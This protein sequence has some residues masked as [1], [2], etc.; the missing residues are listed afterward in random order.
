M[1]GCWH[2]FGRFSDRVAKHDPLIASAFVFVVG[3]IDTLGDIN[4]LAMQIILDLQC[5]P[6]KTLLCVPDLAHAV[7]DDPLDL[8]VDI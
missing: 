5:L 4:R 7:P 1:N 8:H 3:G 6:M 2:Q